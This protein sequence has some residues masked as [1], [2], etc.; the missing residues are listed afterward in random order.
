MGMYLYLS[1]STSPGIPTH[2]QDTSV[3]VTTWLLLALKLDPRDLHRTKAG[4]ED[5]WGSVGGPPYWGLKWECI[6]TP[7][8]PRNGKLRSSR[9]VTGQLSVHLSKWELIPA[10]TKSGGPRKRTLWRDHWRN[11]YNSRDFALFIPLTSPSQN[12]SSSYGINAIL[13]ENKFPF[14]LHLSPAPNI[15]TLCTSPHF[16]F[17]F[18][19][20]SESSHFA[21]CRISRHAQFTTN[22]LHTGTTYYLL[23]VGSGDSASSAAFQRGWQKIVGD[24]TTEA[25]TTFRCGV[26]DSWF[27]INEFNIMTGGRSNVCVPMKV[28]AYRLNAAS[29]NGPSRLAPLSQPDYTR[30]RIDKRLSHD[31]LGDVD[32][33]DTARGPEISNRVTNLA[34]GELRRERFG[35]YIHWVLPRFYRT[36]IAATESAASKLADLRSKHG[37]PEPTGNI[38]ERDPQSPTYRT[39]PP[40]WI[41]VRHITSKTPSNANIPPFQAFVVE[42]DRVSRIIDFGPDVD[43]EVEAS[44]FAYMKDKQSTL[45]EQADIYIGYKQRLNSWQEAGLDSSIERVPLSILSNVNPV[46]A[47]YQPHNV[48]VFSILDNFS[49]E[50]NGVKYLEKATANYYVMG[51]HPYSQEDPFYPPQAAQDPCPSHKDRL[52][53]C[54]MQLTE[55]KSDEAVNWLKALLPQ[56]DATKV[57]LHGA[58][59]QVEWDVYCKPPTVPADVIAKDYDDFSPVSVGVNPI[60]ALLAITHTFAIEQPTEDSKPHPLA[61]DILSLQTLIIKQD[62]DPDA[63]LE[64]AD[65]LFTSYF[66]PANGGGHWH[67]AGAGTSDDPDSPT[68]PENMERDVLSQVNRKQN[69][70]DLCSREAQWIQ[71]QIWAEWWKWVRS[72]VK[73]TDH[74]DVQAK[75]AELVNRHELLI[76]T[77]T[78]WNGEIRDVAKEYNWELSA[79]PRFYTCRDPTVLLCGIKSGWPTDWSDLLKVRLESHIIKMSDI[80]I[81]DSPPEDWDVFQS[82]VSS[83]SGK[84]PMDLQNT[85]RLLLEEFFV[86][87]PLASDTPRQLL[88]QE[89]SVLQQFAS[90][91]PCQLSQQQLSLLQQFAPGQL[92]QQQLPVL[93]QVLSVLQ[94]FASDTPRQLSQQALPVLQQ[95]A[96]DT[97][98]RLSQQALSVLRQFATYILHLRQPVPTNL[99]FPL[100]HDL[101]NSEAPEL[102]VWRD[103]WNAKQPWFPLF[104]EWEIEYYHIDHELWVPASREPYGPPKLRFEIKEEIN[105]ITN[106]RRIGGRSLVLPHSNMMLKNMIDKLLKNK[107]KTDELANLKSAIDKLDLL[108]LSLSS[109]SGQLATKHQNTHLKSTVNVPGYGPLLLPEAVNASLGVIDEPAIRLMHNTSM[110]PY[111]DF[112]DFRDANHS[113]FKPTIHGQF[114]FTKLNVIDKFGQ[115]ISAV[116]PDQEPKLHPYISEFYSCTRDDP[117]GSPITRTVIPDAAQCVQLEPRLNQESRLNGHYV[118]WS[119]EGK[120]WRPATEYEN[121]IWGWLVVNYVDNGLQVFLPDGTF[122]RE[123]RMGG[124]DGTSVGPDSWLPFEAPENSAA[125]AAVP[126]QLLA[127]V[128]KLRYGGYLHE[129]FDVMVE[130]LDATMSTPNHYAG[131]L[132]AITGKPF[133]LINSGWSLQ[134]SHPPNVNQSTSVSPFSEPETPVDL[135]NFQVKFGDKDRT[136]DGLLG[137][138]K[139]REGSANFDLSNFFTYFPGPERDTSMTIVIEKND[140]PTFQAFYDSPLKDDRVKTPAEINLDYNQKL[141]V[142]GMLV[143]PFTPVHAYTGFSPVV[144][145]HLP[146]WALE[147]GLKNITAFFHL[148]PMIV[149]N[150]APRYDDERVLKSGSNLKNM[151][152]PPEKTPSFP[153]PAIGVADWAWLQPYVS[154]DSAEETCF[155]PF[156]LSAIPNEPRLEHT[157]YTAVEGYLYLKQPISR[158]TPPHNQ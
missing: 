61:Q 79:L 151:K 31:I 32:L 77:V 88:R 156:K 11:N 15:G 45:A 69:A 127:L 98:P 28:E 154:P 65:I 153:I 35:M 86:L 46:F 105:D 34:T 50:D 55:D 90:N 103:R 107:N 58:L 102:K 119:D 130:A 6:S 92:S 99:C 25:E 23:G 33:Q 64:A 124:N 66:V 41:V 13:F 12:F 1:P 43:I 7:N 29:A 42:S 30:L 75:V 112:P 5:K 146:Q 67:V 71:W 47:D 131:Y 8:K 74:V 49:Y 59:Y 54:Y 117:P 18:Y 104:V 76:A 14:L 85:C 132:P 155:N 145:L 115:A 39:L 149:P 141:N 63:Q 57:L 40:R 136:F 125:E 111:A 51:W 114:R 126:K 9:G 52:E 81:N 44:P 84:L 37:H 152:D 116:D 24:G 3:S 87:Q 134:L 118:L 129:F 97:P 93:E 95:F 22:P 72:N 53:G 140:Y 80:F 109:I 108:T 20:P 78:N 48:N 26:G 2:A 38:G 148:G 147:Q 113:P 91:T 121:P 137:Y 157:P 122:Y 70:V 82:F 144:T 62:E 128:R 143:D 158:G 89:I 16:P 83:V 106:T 150:D 56:K 123:I 17:L 96:S 120:C 135:Y 101:D 19:T 73:H 36:G 4:T 21:D 68:I 142:F 110:T 10:H 27:L 100:Y 60:D 133:A 139:L 138:F 94:H